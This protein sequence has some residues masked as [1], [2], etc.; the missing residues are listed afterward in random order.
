M[1]G[2]WGFWALIVTDFFGF[3]LHLFSQTKVF[4]VI[5]GEEQTA[6]ML[7]VVIWFDGCPHSMLFGPIN[8]APFRLT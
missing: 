1:L 2:D 7:V 4:F 8:E 5:F 6:S 3:A